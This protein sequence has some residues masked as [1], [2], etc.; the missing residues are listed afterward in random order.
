LPEKVPYI[1]S[2]GERV[3]T[4]VTDLG[5]FEKPAGGKAFVLTAVH[6]DEMGRSV[7]ERVSEI[8]SKTGWELKTA[9]RIEEEPYPTKEE[10][11][12]LRLFDPRRQFIG[13]L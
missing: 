13:K 4:L 9:E 7:E 6:A 2:R 3:K 5:V 11:Y 10:L 8:K 1:S 12:T